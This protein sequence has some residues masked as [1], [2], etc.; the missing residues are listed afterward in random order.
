MVD[1]RPKPFRNIQLTTRRLITYVL[2][3]VLVWLTL[4]HPDLLAPIL[5][6]IGGGALKSLLGL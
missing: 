3:F 1:S 2:F 6:A 5:N 4:I